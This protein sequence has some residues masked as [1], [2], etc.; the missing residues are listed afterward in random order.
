VWGRQRPVPC[1]V[2]Y[3]A[4]VVD[5]RQGVYGHG[6]GNRDRRTRCL[7]IFLSLRWRWL[8]PRQRRFSRRECAACFAEVWCTALPERPWPPAPLLRRR[9][10][11]V[12]P[13]PAWCRSATVAVMTGR[14]A[15]RRV[16]VPRR[17]AHRTADPRQRLVRERHVVLARPVHD[18]LL[19]PPLPRVILLRRPHRTHKAMAENPT[20]VDAEARIERAERLLEQV[21]GRSAL[22]LA[23][24]FARAREEAEDIWA[25]AKSLHASGRP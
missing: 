22:F 7:T 13:G 3:S 24:T 11:R 8:P 15:A 18:R 4:M 12:V 16:G 25:D 2:A 5:V 19:V 21:M 10:P 14:R 9:R 1:V 23:R 6:A 17:R 20:T